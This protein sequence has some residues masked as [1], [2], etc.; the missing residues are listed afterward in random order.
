MLFRSETAAATQAERD[1]MAAMQVGCSMPI[2][3]FAEFETLEKGRF[4]GK[5]DENLLKKMHLKV[6]AY[7]LDGRQ[8]F[9]IENTFAPSEFSAAGATMAAR[10]L[11]NTDCKTLIEKM[12]NDQNPIHAND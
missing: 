2:A 11:E 9:E 12:Q 6:G 10:L 4:Y 7:S 3:A 8:H 5:S 1:F